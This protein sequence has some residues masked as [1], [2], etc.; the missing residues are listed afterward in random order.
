MS[1]LYTNNKQQ[2][3]FCCKIEFKKNEKNVDLYEITLSLKLAVDVT[4]YINIQKMQS[5]IGKKI[6][7]GFYSLMLLFY[8]R[9][10]V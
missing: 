4:W 1:K 6:K 5:F 7:K 10:K 3:L 8:I 2:D 9:S